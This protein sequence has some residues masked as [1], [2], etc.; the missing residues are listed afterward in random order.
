M[1]AIRFGVIGL[2]RGQSFVKACGA[3]GGATVT[4]LYDIDLARAEHVAGQYGLRAFGDFDAFLAADIDAVVVASPLQY[5]AGHSIAALNAGKHVLSEVTACLTV[6]DARALV[7]AARS[8][9]AIYMLSENYRYL[10]EVELLKRMH[11]ERRFGELYYGE[12]EYI[13]DCQ[14]L[15][16]NDD[17]SLTWRGRGFLGVYGTHSLGP[18]LYITGDRVAQVSALAVPGGKYDPRVT[19][20]TMHLLQMV[21]DGGMTLRVRV[22]HVS[23][24]PHQMAYYALQGT[25][26]SYE[27]WRG[28]GDQSKVWLEDEHEPSLFHAAARWHGL[29]EQAPRYIADRLAAPAEARHGGHGTS[30]Y[31]LLHDF[32]ATCRG[33]R[34]ATIDV[35]RGLDYTLPCIYAVES[36]AAHGA[37]ITIPDPRTW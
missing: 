35:Y 28:F 17:A 11:D 4:A 15:W 13:H 2:S 7:Q 31:W 32:L 30:E 18:L 6:D 3:I 21:T 22:D 5:H 20:P 1:C 26:G 23:R 37:P 19:F 33:E 16:F 12:G 9:N 14:G 27:S 29:D 24:R 36:A 34:P 8:S 10:D 25:G